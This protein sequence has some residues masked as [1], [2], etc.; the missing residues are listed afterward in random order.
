MLSRPARAR[1]LKLPPDIDIEA[2]EDV[3]PRAGAWIET[4]LSPHF[5]IP[6]I[7]APRAGAWIETVYLCVGARGHRVAPRAGA[8]IET[9]AY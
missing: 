4:L 2:L 6:T 1:G 5:Y 8:W 7:V 3:A 9:N